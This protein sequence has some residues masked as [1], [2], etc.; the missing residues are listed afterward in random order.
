MGLLVA[1]AVGA[2][3]L[4]YG[5]IGLALVAGWT[6]TRVTGWICLL[7]ASAIAF[8]A[9]RG[10]YRYLERRM[11][12][13]A[14]LLQAIREGDYSVRAPLDDRGGIRE[15]FSEINRLSAELSGARQAGIESDALLGRLL[16]TIDLAVLVFDPSGHLS[17]LNRAAGNLLGEPVSD[18]RGRLADN[19][20]LADWLLRSGEVFVANR[21]FAAGTGPWEVR[22]L[23]FRRGGRIHT[24]L[25]MTDASRTLREEE[26]RAWRRL[27]RVL[28]HELNNSLGPIASVADTLRRQIASGMEG[29][30]ALTEGL[31]LIERR[32]RNLTDFLRRYSDYA[33]MP[34]PSFA[35]VGLAT[36]L[37]Q[38]ILI[39]DSSKLHLKEGPEVI[40]Q[41]DRA[42][43]EQALINLIRNALEATAPLAGA[44]RVD[45]IETPV[46]VVIEIQDEGPGLPQTEN[47][48][49]PFFTTKPGGSGIGLLVAREVAENHGGSL[50]LRDRDDHSGAIAR[51][52]LAKM[53]Q[54]TWVRYNRQN[55]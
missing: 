20:G 18:L 13:G 38:V 42:Q 40:I 3:A 45:W 32:S 1:G 15:L 12:Q 47:L 17:G 6:P 54:V 9:A 37:R 24:L 16:G 7:G 8:L 25:V 48:F 31:E 14:A 11:R 41:A 49:V 52:H 50:E 53:P 35:P 44:V 36:L 5:A 55:P 23:K 22:V 33:R 21:L 2:A 27:I 28:G 26:R 10:L 43:L 19:L 51:L 29:A 46:K 30:G 39:Q 4:P 34:P